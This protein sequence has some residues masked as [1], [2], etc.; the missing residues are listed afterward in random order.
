MS[1]SAVP[2]AQREVRAVAVANAVDVTEPAAGFYKVKLSRDTVLRAVQLWYGPPA[3]PVT[4][5]ELDRSWRWQAMLD[6]GALIDL[7]RV[8]P[9]CAR[10]P[11]TE[12]EFKRCSARVEWAREHAPTSAYAERGVKLDPLSTDM[13]LPF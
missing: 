4:G 6:D 8:W 1:R 12:Q 9:V 10:D 5:E 13:P 11:I 2:Y 7:D 3:D